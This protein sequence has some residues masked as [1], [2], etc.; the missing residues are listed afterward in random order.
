MRSSA[1]LRRHPGAAFVVMGL[2]FVCFALATWNLVYLFRAN[3]D[4][5]AQH[6]V[7]ALGDGAALQLFQLLFWGA[8]GLA[9][10]LVFKACEKI[11]V[12]RLTREE[13]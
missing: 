1:F 4:L 2:S 10:Y 6:G 5:I 9:L 3:F 7:M 8:V 11:L 12:E 13:P